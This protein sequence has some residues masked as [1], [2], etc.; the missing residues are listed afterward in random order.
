MPIFVPK[1]SF[2]GNVWPAL[3]GGWARLLMALQYQF[4]QSQWLSEKDIR[5]LQLRQLGRLLTHA[6]QTVPFYRERLDKVGLHPRGRVTAQQWAK[7]PILYRKDIQQ[8]GAALHSEKMPPGHG[9]VSGI[10]TSGST[11]TPVHVLRSKMAMLFF[12]AFTMRD[13]NWQGFD[14]TKKMA[15]IRSS[16]KGDA[17][18]PNGGVGRWGV[19]TG[20]VPG[21]GKAVTLNITCTA[22]Q[23]MDWLW[24]QDPQYLLSF[25]SNIRELAEYSLKNNIKL[26]NLRKVQTISEIVTPLVRELCREAW[27][28]EVCDIYSS[29]EVGYMALQCPDHEHYHVQS[30]GTMVEILDDQ[31]ESCSP[32]QTGRV[33]VT[34]MH[35]F[36]MPLLRYDIGD[37]AEAGEVCP[38]GRGL[39]VLKRIIGREQ[40]L[41]VLPSGEKR[42]TLLSSTNI[43][44]FLA[45]APIRQFQFVQKDVRAIEV[46]LAVERGLTAGEED[47]LRGWVREKF[48]PSCAVNFTYHGEIAKD[49]SGK[50]HD[51]ICEVK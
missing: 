49:A 19:I 21:A 33:V 48:S 8:A 5:S 35:N 12:D 39:P 34:P 20:S 24:R 10:F 23:Q 29:R 45:I 31:G 44:S 41:L 15:V 17:P 14:L 37:Y 47:G 50:F 7:V 16:K 4:E 18:Y 46:R 30:E 38:C 32:G 40:N 27:G 3:P 6:H 1:S 2:E 36:A 11:G 22:Q 9:K 51:F 25:P 42:A 26:P 13:Q 28:V 43:K